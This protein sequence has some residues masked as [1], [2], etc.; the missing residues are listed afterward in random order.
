MDSESLNS[1]THD[2]GGTPGDGPQSFSTDSLTSVSDT[3]RL[4]SFEL[5]H[6]ISTR[7]TERSD[8]PELIQAADH[9]LFTRE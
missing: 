5:V 9:L 1:L 6:P 4:P 7:L 3:V 8:S 2:R